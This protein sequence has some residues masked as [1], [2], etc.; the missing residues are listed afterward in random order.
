[1]KFGKLCAPRKITSAAE[2]PVWY[3]LQFQ[4]M[5]VCREFPSRADIRHF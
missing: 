5:R 1:M 3:A 4:Q 2:N